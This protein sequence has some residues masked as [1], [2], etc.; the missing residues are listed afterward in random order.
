MSRTRS[1]ACAAVVA[2]SLAACGS[3]SASGTTTTAAT[4]PTPSSAA[5]VET[6]TVETGTVA[7]PAT[8]DAATD[9]SDATIETLETDGST[10]D[11]SDPFA[12]P[13]IEL[14]DV[15]V[16]VAFGRLV[17]TSFII[18]F[19]TLADEQSA[20]VERAE[21]VVYPALV[22]DVA[23]VRGA[24]PAELEPTLE[25]LLRRVDAAPTSLAAGGFT[26]AEI[27]AIGETWNN[28][29]DDVIRSGSLANLADPSEALDQA[30]L[31][32]AEP[33]FVAAVGTFQDYISRDS[34]S[35]LD[36]AGDAWFNDTCPKL[37]ASLS[38]E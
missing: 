7:A 25:P 16:C 26:D 3:D 18:S 2:L 27:A 23:T 4:T 21:L 24:V 34:S 5:T 37:S 29:L 38:T 11:T 36:E 20:G 1:I 32:A 35:D 13:D 22:D 19:V 31:D 17:Y 6:A 30:K 10:A 14:D 9:Q 33:A 15:P 12:I 28:E 8:T